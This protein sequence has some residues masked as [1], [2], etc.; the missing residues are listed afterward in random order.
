M[1]GYHFRSIT[2]AWKD[3][4]LDGPAA[5]S[6]LRTP[7]PRIVCLCGSTRF[8]P[9]FQ[10]ASLQETLAGRIVLSVG[11]AI[12]SDAEHFG[13]LPAAER[14]AIK[15]VLDELHLHKIALADECLVLNVGGYVGESTRR[16]LAYAVK[17]GKVIRW[18]EPDT[19]L[20]LSV[21]PPFD[22]IAV[23]VE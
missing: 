7:P 2:G 1:S 3:L 22:L 23:P 20:P 9:T 14:A 21:L 5:G 8:W 6:D 11:A 16:E 13:H 15:Q 17:H 19:A 4:R 10:E 12:K 18:W